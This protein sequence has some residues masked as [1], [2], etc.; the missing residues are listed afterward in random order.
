MRVQLGQINLRK[1]SCSN[2]EF[3]TYAA[4]TV[5]NKKEQVLFALQEPNAAEG[6]IVNMPSAQLIYKRTF[7][8]K[9]ITEWPRAA[10]FCSKKIN[11]VPMDSYI[12]K[13][14]VAAVWNTGN[15]AVPEIVV[16]SVY[17]DNNNKDSEPWP[18]KFLTLVKHCFKTHKNIIILGDFNSWSPLWGETSTTKRGESIEN[19]IYNYDLQVL[20]V[21]G[22]PHV[23]TYEKLD[24]N[25]T[26]RT[27]IDVSVSNSAIGHLMEDWQVTD[28]ILTSDHRLIK[29]YLDLGKDH[30][31]KVRNLAKGDWEKFTN[32][33]NQ[34]NWVHHDKW[35]VP[36]L[37]LAA[38]RFT[39]KITV[40]MDV[41]HPKTVKQFKLNRPI[42]FDTE[43]EQQQRLI[44]RKYDNWR[45][46]TY[47]KKKKVKSI[48]NPFYAEWKQAEKDYNKLIARKKKETWR[49]FVSGLTTIESTARFN[50]ILNRANLNAMGI[51]NDEKGEPFKT[52]EGSLDRLASEHFPDCLKSP[53]INITDTNTEVKLN[54]PRADFI[55][56]QKVK[57]AINSFKDF[58]AAA[59]DEIKPI[60][61]KHIGEKAYERLTELYKASYL[62]GYIPTSWRESRVIFIPKP[63]KDNYSDPRSYRPISLMT[64]LIKAFEKLM[65][66]RWQA[67]F[68][69]TNPLSI[70]Q[71]GFCKGKS[72]D[73]ALSNVVEYIEHSIH[74]KKQYTLAV[75]LDIRGAFDTLICSSIVKELKNK[76]CPETDA[77]WYNHL[78]NSRVINIEYKG[79]TITRYLTKGTPQGGCLSPIMWNVVFDSLLNNFK[80]NKRVKAIGFADDC[81]LLVS[82]PQPAHLAKLMQSAVNSAL[83]WGKQQKLEFSAPKTA[84]IL[85]T[86]K[87]KIIM[88]PNIQMNGHVIPYSEKT[89]YL[90]V[91]L[92]QKLNWTFHIKEK[93]K[94]AKVQLMRV[95]N[96]SGKA[97][98]MS[99]KFGRWT[100]QAIILAG[101]KHGHL[102]WH[103]SLE[104]KHIADR[105]QSIQRQALMMLGLMRKSTPT[106]GL[107]Q[108]TYVKPIKLF[109]RQESLLAYYRT[110]EH[111]KIIPEIMDNPPSKTH[112]GHRAYIRQYEKAISFQRPN[113]DDMKIDY[114]W[115]KHYKIDTDSFIDGK[116]DDIAEIN[117]YTDGS[118]IQDGHAGSGYVIYQNNETTA[119]Q[120]HYLGQKVTVFQ[121]EIYAIKKAV[122]KTMEIVQMGA[123]PTV[124]INSDSRA[125]L[126]ALMNV[127]VKS[128]VVND[129][130]KKLNQLSQ[131]AQVNLRWVKSHVNFR[132]N[133]TADKLAKAGAANIG[134]L[135]I[136]GPHIQGTIIRSEIREKTDEKWTEQW[137]AEPRFRQTKFFFQNVNKKLAFQML[138][139][140]REIFSKVARWVTGHDFFNRHNCLVELGEDDPDFTKCRFCDEEDETPWHLL[141]RCPN[142]WKIR[143]EI[144]GTVRLTIPLNS[145]S[146]CR[147][148]EF[149]KKTKIHERTEDDEL[150]DVT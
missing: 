65:L 39:N 146:N 64:I 127:T 26:I 102:V 89:K 14:I 87:N 132:G 125:A 95:R 10:L 50:K 81:C 144:F 149:L 62:L 8:H 3:N 37:E 12:D 129:T 79:T 29:F 73:S 51:L 72:T 67:T 88:P 15:A 11:L 106:A 91:Y 121:C 104:K 60:V 100:Y 115:E 33:M 61:L 98:G 22:R 57:V 138:K 107:E 6:F 32:K 38:K 13:D 85:F 135:E 24:D 136:D 150:D 142:F 143:Q 134:S 58:K 69:K 93:I 16:T 76:G 74:V 31:I 148:I 23:Y 140:K 45:N 44:K 40:A 53:K 97:W 9:V 101:L 47:Y 119:E 19:V 86:N 41:S 43:V 133:E 4:R 139:N 84:A 124:L 128:K 49:D 42:W 5:N 90:G 27:I 131:S 126:M 80:K 7:N 110:Q 92:D 108:I 130:R 112:I 120:S 35:N 25:K 28:E 123:R 122:E 52:V 137:V 103:Q 96:A 99:P 2:L 113:T 18:K 141:A 77:K 34:V 83:K 94:K 54:D 145:F 55:T 114:Q 78:L 75:F 20:N 70:N 71:H 17:M 109:L 21:G 66:M 116:P 30:S 63:G 46:K 68:L 1:R 56:I 111:I 105:F 117:I 36:K 118:K 82:G 48:K 147:L 59:S